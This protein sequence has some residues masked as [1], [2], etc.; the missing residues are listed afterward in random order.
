MPLY[1]KYIMDC[2]TE[3]FYLG[4][5]TVFRHSIVLFQGQANKLTAE[6]QQL[7]KN[8]QLSPVG[9]DSSTELRGGGG[10]GICTP[11]GSPQLWFMVK[12]VR[13]RK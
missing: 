3:I 6:E 1:C 9:G 2:S 7:S 11:K 8:F 13:K 12:N 10:L 5:L 4:F